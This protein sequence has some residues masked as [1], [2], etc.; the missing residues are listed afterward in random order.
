MGRHQTTPMDHARN[1]LFRH[2]IR[3]GVL[4]AEMADR[5]EW[6][7]DTI[8]YMAERHPRLTDLQLAHLEVIGRRF[9]KPAIPHGAATTAMN[10]K[11][12]Q[13]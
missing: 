5:L 1:D 2:I 3:C 9:I 4:D 12:W 11:E 13:N 7:D 8:D 10:R 6:L